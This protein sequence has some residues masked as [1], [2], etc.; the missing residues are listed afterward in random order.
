MIEQ[1][2]SNTSL[3]KK[4]FKNFN[5]AITL[6]IIV[7]A[8]VL[9]YKKANPFLDDPT[10]KIS[11]LQDKLSQQQNAI[12][13]LQNSLQKQMADQVEWKVIVIKHLIQMADLTLNTNGDI[14]V[15]LAFLS[16]AKKY[17]D[18]DTALA[19]ISH[20]LNKDIVSL[21]AE[22]VVDTETLVL[23][24]D[25]INQKIS[26]LSVL[27]PQNTFLQTQPGET[28]QQK[29][30]LK[31]LF[32]SV[33]KALKDIVIVHH[34]TTEPI[35]APDQALILRL[36]LQAKLFQAEIAVMQKQNKL[37]QDC[38]SQV[39]NLISRFFSTNTVSVGILQSLKELQQINLKQNQPVLITESLTAIQAEKAS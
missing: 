11:A 38:L 21:E 12:Q 16:S 39:H 25:A 27:Q 8:I 5:I 2:D 23:K 13:E 32:T 14:K 37:Y 4:I 34:Q 7:V 6:L 22:G 10:E 15:A 3:P 28:L 31:R 33:T 24:I 17:A 36:N 26:S 20:A 29:A 9:F 1:N 19:S 35:L 30:L 18:N